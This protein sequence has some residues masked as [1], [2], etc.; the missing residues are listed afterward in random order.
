[1]AP[2]PTV[3]RGRCYCGAVAVRAS[4]TP[5]V[6]AYCHCADC[7]RW[8]GAPVA[9]FA[10]FSEGRVSID[11]APASITTPAGVERWFCGLCGSALAARF[12]YLPGQIYVPLGLL[13][14]AA[15]L[16]PEL[17]AHADA[18]LPWL[19]LADDL[20]RSVGSARAAL[21]EAGGRNGDPA[22]DPMDDAIDGA[23]GGAMGGATDGA[24]GDA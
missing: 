2:A 11:P 15:A 19:R 6:V 7:R 10:A 5:Q 1:M 17:H 23:M 3:H 9:A 4:G 12:P 13:D 8:T 14:T 24:V 16:A 20:P 21:G 22:D 18:A